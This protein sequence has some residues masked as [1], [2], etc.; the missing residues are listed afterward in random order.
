MDDFKKELF[1]W[2]KTIVIAVVLAVFITNFIIV[3]AK[4]PSG[5]ME[6]T[7][8]TDDRIIA[9]RLTYLFGDPQRG[10]IVVFKF[11]D[12]PQQ[13]TLYVKRIIG[14]PGETVEIIDGKVYIDGAEEPLDD[15]FTKEVPV[16]T[17]GPFE[18]PEDSYFMMG[19]NRNNSSDSRFWE[20]KYVKRDKILGKVFLRY[21]PSFKIYKDNR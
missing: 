19:D 10:D 12:D 11:P 7:I 17:Y 3:N 6:N 9:S 15:S 14:L 8:M 5:S 13:K 1:S 18:V 21:F 4:V 2:I 16:G 20:N